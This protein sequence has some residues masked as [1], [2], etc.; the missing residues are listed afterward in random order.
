VP[1][2]RTYIRVH[3][4]MDEHPK[5]EPLSD[6]AFRLLMT[7]WFYCSRNR[8]DGQIRNVVW[9]KRGTAKARRELVE[10]GLVVPHDGYV[11]MHDYLEHQRSAEEIRLLQD[12]RHDTGSYGNH[13]RWHV[14]RRRPKADCEHCQKDPDP[15]ANGI[16]NASQTDRKPLASTEAEAEAE[17]KRSVRGGSHVSSGNG[18]S[19]PPRFPDHCQRH[20]NVPEP[21]PCGACADA[22]KAAA[23]APR[24]LSV[25]SP[26]A[27]A[28][29]P[30][31]GVCDQYRMRET[32]FGMIRCPECHPRAAEA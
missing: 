25:V 3:D 23:A 4:G 13:V 16:A 18:S 9:Q 5:V 32:P 12:T 26:A 17:E 2:D 8:T 6:A 14:V 31:C 7:G 30:H 24:L 10:A 29:V 20:A 11:L 19:P 1:D 15:I 27:P 21:G 22:R 28:K